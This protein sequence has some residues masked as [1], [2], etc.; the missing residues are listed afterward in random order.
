MPNRFLPVLFLV[1]GAM[2]EERL[3]QAF[4]LYEE[5]VHS[6]KAGAFQEAIRTAKTSP[7]SSSTNAFL[8]EG[9]CHWRLTVLDY[10]AD[11]ASGIT[12]NAK[13]TEV[14]L[15]RFERLSSPT[16]L[17]VA[18]RGLAYQM[19]AGQGVRSAIKNGPKASEVVSWLEKAAPNAYWTHFVRA[20]NE[21]KAPGFAGGDE[22][23]ALIA[24]QALATEYPD[25][26]AVT[27]HL[28]LALA[29]TGQKEKSLSVIREITRKY[30]NDL[31]ARK[32][33]RD[34]EKQ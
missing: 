2:A 14:A 15:Q 5:G 10:L 34:I 21:L 24:F 6:W 4:A 20:V 27:L 13:Q 19:L 1:L 18:V 23:K 3:N 12:A 30:P 16:V 11:N 25:S 31:W 26:T 29:A 9:L 22:K 17:S 33:M 7:E 32:T 8:L 28:A